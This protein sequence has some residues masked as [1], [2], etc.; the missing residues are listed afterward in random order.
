MPFRARSVMD[1]PVISSPSSRMRPWVG[2]RMPAMTLAR[3][4][5]PP[6]VGSGDGHEPLAD[7][8][9]DI[10]QDALVVAVL[11]HVIADML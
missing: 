3:V 8:Q 7:G 2:V 6:S 9:I 1:R 11:F 10:A 5:F 4:D